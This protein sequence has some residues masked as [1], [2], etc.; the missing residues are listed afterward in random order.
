M[1]P[2]RSCPTSGAADRLDLGGA[3][4]DA[5]HKPA[6]S[7]LVRHRGDPPVDVAFENPAV[8]VDRPAD[9]FPDGAGAH[10]IQQALRA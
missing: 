6:G 8:L 3:D 4:S 9:D 7:R 1:S 2:V 10:L 5:H